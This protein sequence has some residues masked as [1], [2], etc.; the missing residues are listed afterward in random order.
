[1]DRVTKDLMSAIFSFL[2]DG[3]NPDD[4]DIET[5][6]SVVDEAFAAVNSIL[7][8]LYEVRHDIRRTTI[9]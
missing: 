2:L 6:M 7:K 8:D 3:V 9:A 5:E 1:M 4:I